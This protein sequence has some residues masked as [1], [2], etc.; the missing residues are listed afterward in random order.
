MF[1]SGKS[2]NNRSL[3]IYGALVSYMCNLTKSCS[4]EHVLLLFQCIPVE[5]YNKTKIK[6]NTITPNHFGIPFL[7]ELLH[8][9]MLYI[10]YKHV[11]HFTLSASY[12]NLE[13]MKL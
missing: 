4:C 12:G 9:G 11:P 10:K 1:W 13:A 6:I 3:T 2:N 7:P 5:K 8:F